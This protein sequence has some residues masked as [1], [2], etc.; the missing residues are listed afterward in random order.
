MTGAQKKESPYSGYILIALAAL[1]LWIGGKFDNSIGLAHHQILIAAPELKDGIFDETVLLML[2]HTKQSAL[3]VVLNKPA[4]EGDYFVGGPMEQ[5]KRVYMLHSLDVTLPETVAVKSFNLGV[6]EGQEQ[7]DKM[8]AAAMKPAWYRV[9]RGYA[10]WGKRQLAS[11][12]D[13]GGWQIVLYDE[14][15]IR[16]TRPEE[17]WRK[18]QTMPMLQVTH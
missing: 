2:K 1:L 9:I 13:R 6:L 4:K 5:D 14:K 7:V 15:F 10:G 16:E 18:A 11:E 17:M 8:L 3:G 12:L